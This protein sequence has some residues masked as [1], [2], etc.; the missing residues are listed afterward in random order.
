MSRSLM[1]WLYSC[2]S[3]AQSSQFILVMTSLQDTQPGLYK[4]SVALANV[5][6]LRNEIGFYR[7]LG[8]YSCMLLCFLLLLVYDAMTLLFFLVNYRRYSAATPC[9]S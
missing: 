6:C 8:F 7:A 4:L 2:T 1:S 5:H 9:P 3:F